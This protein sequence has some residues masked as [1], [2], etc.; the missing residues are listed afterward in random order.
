M[1]TNYS[2]TT[3]SYAANATAKQVEHWIQRGQVAMPPRGQ[4]SEHDVRHL[5][6]I[7][8]LTRHG[9]SVAEA[10]AVWQEH[11]AT[12]ARLIIRR[13][14]SGELRV[15]DLAVYCPPLPSPTFTHIDLAAIGKRVRRR[16]ANLAAV[17]GLE[18]SLMRLRVAQAELDG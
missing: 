13:E 15:T 1:T 10:E 3:A 9:L 8:E 11:G 17:P 5:A 14:P 12:D 6:V 2:T 18:R 7:G 16:L 4:W